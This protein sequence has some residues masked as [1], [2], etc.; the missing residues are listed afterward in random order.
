MNSV[1]LVVVVVVVVMVMVAEQHAVVVYFNFLVVRVPAHGTAVLGAAHAVVR[2]LI[3][4]LVA[5]QALRVE[6]VR[7]VEQGRPLR[8]DERLETDGTLS[9]AALLRL[10]LDCLPE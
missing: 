6:H 1:V 2:L 8:A 5:M 7:A 10:L 4:L 9:V 3:V